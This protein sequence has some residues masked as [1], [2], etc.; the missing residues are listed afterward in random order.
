LGEVRDRWSELG[1]G[2]SFFDISRLSVRE[3]GGKSEKHGDLAGDE[4]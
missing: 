4:E 1:A 3:V 2:R